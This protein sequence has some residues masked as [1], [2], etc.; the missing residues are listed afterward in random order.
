MGVVC[1]TNIE[2]IFDNEC[3]SDSLLKINNNFLNLEGSICELR[4]RVDSQVEVRT[5]F[6]YGPNAASNPASGMVDGGTSRPS[7]MTIQ[8]FVN[9]PTEL[10]LP[11]VSKPKDVAYVIYQKTGF[12]SSTNFGAGG[13][14]VVVTNQIFTP[15]SPTG[16]SYGVWYNVKDY[17]SASAFSNGIIT[18]IGTIT[19]SF[20]PFV[21]APSIPYVY[22][23]S[24]RPASKV[25]FR[26]NRW[27]DTYVE[28]NQQTI[29]FAEGTTDNKL[30]V[31]TQ[32]RPFQ[33]YETAQFRF[34]Y[35]GG[36]IP[37]GVTGIRQNAAPIKGNFTTTGD[38]NYRFS[39]VFII[40]RLTCQ[41]SLFYTVDTGFPKFSRAQ[42]SFAGNA[43]TW[44]NPQIWTEY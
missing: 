11:P 33:G 30:V 40:W 17:F 18:S 28:W 35:T 32:S 10:N 36:N 21:N 37:R 19:L 42:Q 44:N 2:E 23:A 38:I 1:N 26:L 25:L 27:D 7:D 31:S 20:R 8:A 12:L 43:A 34:D 3:L 9:S 13:G 39:P 24:G 41:D 16:L 14:S 6:Y 22:R 4:Q 29:T 5:F 15:S